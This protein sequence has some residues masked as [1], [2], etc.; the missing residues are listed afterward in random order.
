[1]SNLRRF[2]LFSR[3]KTKQKNGLSARSRKGESG[4]SPRAKFPFHLTALRSE[5]GD[6]FRLCVRKL[7]KNR[8]EVL[9]VGER[10][11]NRRSRLKDK[12]TGV[13][14]GIPVSSSFRSK[15]ASVSK[16][17]SSCRTLN[18][19][20]VRTGCTCTYSC[21]TAPGSTCRTDAS[22]TYPADTRRTSDRSTNSR[23]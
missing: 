19:F 23:F 16:S 14:F 6:P 22:S 7:R 5:V 21:S 9:R 10:R 13:P 12:K 18:N 15:S 1:M 17:S 8:P 20:S 3:R 4:A 2:G 11:G